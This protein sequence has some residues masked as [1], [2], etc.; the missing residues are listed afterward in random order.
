MIQL[1]PPIAVQ[2]QGCNALALVLIDDGVGL[3]QRWVVAFKSGQVETV[4]GR[5]VRV[6][7]GGLAEGASDAIPEMV[8]RDVP[9]VRRAAQAVRL[10]VWGPVDAGPPILEGPT[11][12][13]VA[14]IDP[15]LE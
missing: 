5:D 15:R 14:A 12:V 10:P 1:V 4:P 3:G 13:A 11:G 6:S 2:V 9:A 8:E 7:A